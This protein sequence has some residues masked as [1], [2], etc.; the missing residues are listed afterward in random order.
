MNKKFYDFFSSW[1]KNIFD[2]GDP[3]WS[4]ISKYFQVPIVLEWSN[5]ARKSIKIFLTL[6]MLTK[7]VKIC[8]SAF[9]NIFALVPLVEVGTRTVLD[10]REL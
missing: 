9:I 1:S 3:C 5:L 10:I 4:K 2:L 7:N 6:V 8:L